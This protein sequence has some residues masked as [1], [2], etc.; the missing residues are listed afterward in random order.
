MNN[1]LIAVDCDGV[2]LDYNKAFGE[3]YKL[4][5]GVNL[6]VKNVNSYHAH[7]YYDLGVD[8]YKEE[9]KSRFFNTFNAH[10]WSSMPACDGAVEAINSLSSAG[11]KIAVIT[12]M[13]Q[14]FAEARMDNLRQLGF[15][16]DSLFAS[17]RT[18]TST[19][20]KAKFLLN[21]HPLVFVDDLIDNFLDIETLQTKKILI[22]NKSH[23]SPNLLKDIRS[24]DE[25]YGNIKEFSL[26]FL[27]LHNANMTQEKKHNRI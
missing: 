20:P 2:L 15:M 11:Y 10:G 5:F 18:S 13:P 27:K 12:S 24:V 1:N 17:G 26:S 22:D 16:V 23:D 7:N 25:K 4:T 9:N 14:E 6:N 8:F 19:N 3:I 21:L